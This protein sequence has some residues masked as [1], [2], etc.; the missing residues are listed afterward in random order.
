M[1]DHQ[2]KSSG[3]DTDVGRYYRGKYDDK[4]MHNSI[5]IRSIS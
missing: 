2:R 1:K 5:N 4:K 3:R